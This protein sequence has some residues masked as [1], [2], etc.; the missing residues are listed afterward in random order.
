MPVF[1]RMSI[2]G[3]GCQWYLFEACVCK[4]AEWS[5]SLNGWN[6]TDLTMRVI[7]CRTH[8]S[9]AIMVLNGISNHQ[10]RH[11]LFN[12]LFR[13]RSKKTSKLCVTGLCAGNSPVTGE[14]PT[15]MASNAE[16]VSIWW[17]HH[18][19]WQSWADRNVTP[20]NYTLE[21]LSDRFLLL[22]QPFQM[23]SSD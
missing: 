17:R 18:E 8:Y 21:E 3:C 23:I 12:R 11:C 10:P 19:D 9:D 1:V 16:N 13:H 6:A 7:W 20:S 14:F 4:Y 2:F 5:H 15:Q 22:H